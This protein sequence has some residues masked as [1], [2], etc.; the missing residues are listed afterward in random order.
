MRGACLCGQVQFEAVPDGNVIACHCTQCRKQSGHFWA[1]TFAAHQGFH[2]IRGETLR[3][4]DASPQARR[5]FCNCCGAFLFWQPTGEAR[6][7]IAAGAFEGPTGFEIRESWFEASAGDYHDPAGGPP[8]QASPAKEIRGSCL[9]GANRFALAQPMGAVW[10]CHCR[11]CRKTSG[12]FSTSFDVAEDALDWQSR[13]VTEF[14]GPGGSMRGFCT[15]CA[16]GLYFRAADGAFAVEAGV[17]DNPTGGR[18]AGHIF[19]ADKGDYYALTDGLPQY[20]GGH[21]A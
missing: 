16:S 5:G 6:L 1:A 15:T 2:L 21:P 11:Q 7:C 12:H 13:H 18:L 20:P 8:P 10:A 9:C 3:W 19:V 4:Y 14:G 17:I